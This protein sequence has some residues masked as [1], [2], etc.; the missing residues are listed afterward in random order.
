[1]GSILPF[2]KSFYQISAPALYSTWLAEVARS[3]LTSNSCK[4]GFPVS[5]YRPDDHYGAVLE[6]VPNAKEI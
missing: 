2:T 6:T 4:T 3:A 1:M 5:S